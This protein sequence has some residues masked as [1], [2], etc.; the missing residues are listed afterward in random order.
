MLIDT[1]RQRISTR[2]C[3]CT[4]YH[5]VLAAVHY[6]QQSIAEPSDRHSGPGDCS[7]RQ[8]ALILTDL[9]MFYSEIFLCF[10]FLLEVK[11]SRLNN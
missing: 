6:H 7:K 9:E 5:E 2:G 8:R 11:I 1:V 3:N 10:D 4:N